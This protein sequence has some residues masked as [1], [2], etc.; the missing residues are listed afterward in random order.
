M[1]EYAEVL[2]PHSLPLAKCKGRL[3]KKEIHGHT[4]VL[5][6]LEDVEN[7]PLGTG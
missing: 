1:G 2:V 5:S 4:G 7:N 6:T 3:V